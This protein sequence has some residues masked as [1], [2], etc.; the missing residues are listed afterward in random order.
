MASL[1]D[2]QFLIHDVLDVAGHF[3]ALTQD[4]SLDRAFIDGLLEEAHRFTEGEI[5]PCNRSGDVEGCQL[6]NGVVTTPAG[7][8]A[9]YRGYIDG[10]WAGLMGPVEY[11]GQGLPPTFGLIVEELMCTANM[12]FSMY[13]GLSRGCVHAL[14]AHGSDEQ[15]RLFLPRL[16]TGEWTGTMC[17][18]EAQAGSDVG[19]ARTRAEARPDGS[20]SITG[21]KIFISAGEH[22]LADNIIHLVLARTADAPAGTRGISMFVVP[23]INLDG[24]RNQVSCSA[25][26]NKMGIH[27]NATCVL[28]FDGARGY[29]VGQEQQGMKYMFTMMNS[30][31][32]GVGLQGVCL[33]QAGFELSSAYAHDRLQMRSLAGPRYPDKPADPIVVHPDVRRMLLTQRAF[34]EGGRALAY[35]AS[36]CV[37]TLSLGRDDTVRQRA[38]ELLDF[39]TPI[40]KGF[41]TEGGFAAVNDAVQVFGGH[42]FI[43]ETGVEQ[44][45]RDSRITL[46]YEGTTQIQALDLLARKVLMTQGKGLGHLVAEMHAVAADC[47][48]EFPEMGSRLSAIADEW[49]AISM[50]IG[51]KAMQNAEEVGA[52]SVD[53]LFYSGYAVL[54][55]LWARIALAAKRRLGQSGDAEY[56]AGKVELARFYYARVLPQLVA[57]RDAMLAGGSTLMDVRASVFRADP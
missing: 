51:G 15:K 44:L 49:T 18:T 31:R 1:K 33:A 3:R 9:A 5:K 47:A 22:D 2:M 24:T 16:L 34:I 45:V 23:K 35:F 48:G 8:R 56:L 32:I 43:R 38:Q 4:D 36:Q 19:L 20:W 28:N 39:L 14:T 10:G 54:A 46:I 21:T 57:H 12:A 40:V 27:G 55:W 6:S 25:I 17:L 42:G 50:Q 13:P 7:F 29:L 41:L 30:A 26:E 52:A 11:G 37:D 53:Y